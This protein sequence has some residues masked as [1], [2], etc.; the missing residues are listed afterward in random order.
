[1]YNYLPRHIYLLSNLGL[2]G[3]SK[4]KLSKET[5]H[6]VQSHNN[7]IRTI[8]KI[9]LLS[10]FSH[11]YILFSINNVLIMLIY[12]YCLE[13]IHDSLYQGWLARCQFKVTVWGIMFIC[14]MVLR[15]GGTLNPGLSVDQLLQI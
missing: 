11:A 3:A 8:V 4:L 9:D 1:M 13:F 14:G 2:C 6:T 12:A 5:S 10:A 7:W 15:C